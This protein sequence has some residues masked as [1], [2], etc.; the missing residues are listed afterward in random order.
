MQH[1]NKQHAPVDT[2]RAK[3][4][5]IFVRSNS[6]SSKHAMM[7]ESAGRLSQSDHSKNVKMAGMSAVSARREQEL[8]KESPSAASTKKRPP[9]HTAM[10]D[11]HLTTSS[12]ES[13]HNEAK[14]QRRVPETPVPLKYLQATFAQTKSGQAYF[15]RQ[16]RQKDETSTHNK[17]FA[18]PGQ[19]T[20][21]AYDTKVVDAVRAGNVPELRIMLQ[22]DADTKEAATADQSCKTNRF[23]ACNRFGESII[24]MACRRGNEEVVRFLVEEAKVNLFVRDDFGRTPFHDTCWTS[25]PNY[26]VMDILLKRVCQLEESPD[27]TESLIFL[28][29]TE[30]VRGHT[31]FH[32]SRRESWTGWVDF[33]QQRCSTIIRKLQQ[34]D[35]HA[36]GTPQLTMN[37]S[38]LG[39]V[40]KAPAT[41]TLHKHQQDMASMSHPFVVA[42][43]RPM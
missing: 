33:L 29:V 15:A 25:T 3:G 36:A 32:Y 13:S 21:D 35:E 30:D 10:S 20:I 24:H 2:S 14:R 22:Q 1:A 4:G 19:E 39:P 27:D 31:P 28:L 38:T 7:L 43:P 37:D 6:C 34:M 40:P 8:A 41:A 17:F 23:N 12:R 42:P 16:Q 11:S 26:A 18:K 5:M 9:L